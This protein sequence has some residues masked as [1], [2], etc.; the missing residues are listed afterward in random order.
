[1]VTIF[2]PQET[3]FISDGLGVIDKIYMDG[4]IVHELNGAYYLEMTVAIDEEKLFELIDYDNI[5]KAN[6]QLFRIV[7]IEKDTDFVYAKALHIFYDLSNNFLED[8]APT[9]KS[10]GDALNWILYRTV[11][12]N[13]FI[14]SSDIAN[15]KSARYVRYSPTDAIMGRL[16]NSILNTWGGEINR[17]NYSIE[18][19]SRLGQ[20]TDVEISYGKNITGI[21]ETIIKTNVVTKIMPQGFDG[22]ILPEKYVES[23]YILSYPMPV[24]R[25][26]EFKDIKVND[27]PDIG[28]VVTEAQAYDMLR[29]AAQSKFT[30]DK[31]DLPLVNYK[32]NFVDLSQTEEYKEYQVLETLNMGDTATVK[33]ERLGITVTARVIRTVWDIMRE[34]YRAIEIGNFNQ[35]LQSYIRQVNE[36]TKESI[37]IDSIESASQLIRDGLGGYTKKTREEFLIMDTTDE[38]TAQELWRW[39]RNGLGWSGTGYNGTYGIALTKDGKINASMIKTGKLLAEYIEAVSLSAISAN[40]GVITTGKLL[41][42]DGSVS[43]DIDNKEVKVGSGDNSVNTALKFNGMEVRDDQEVIA[44]FGE[45]GAV[46]PK[47]ESNVLNFSNKTGVYYVGG[48]YPYKSISECLNDLFT[49]NDKIH[50]GPAGAPNS[51]DIYIEVFG[52]INETVRITG[53]SGRG[54]LIIRINDGVTFNGNFE[55][56]GN[57]L[58]IYIIGGTNS[59]IKNPGNV[60]GYMYRISACKYVQIN[61]LNLDN[62]GGYYLADVTHGST[63]HFEECDVIN[64]NYMAQANNASSVTVVECKGNVISGVLRLTE[65]A[66]GYISGSAPAGGSLEFS[67]NKFFFT[68]G[69]VARVDSA[70]SPPPVTSKEFI[71]VFNGATFDSLHHGT[72]NVSA[73]YGA[74]AAQNRWDSQTGWFDGRIRFGSEIYNFFN[75]GSNISI[76]MRLRRKNTS[77]GSSAAVM[78]APYNHSASFPSGATRGGWTGWATIPSSLFTSGGATLTYYNGVQGSAGYAIWDAIEVEVTVTKTV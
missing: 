43:V 26:I 58:P 30:R 44:A 55:L 57:T 25:K 12:P 48:A 63:V 33:H 39:N 10:C 21:Q 36:E 66:K 69:T 73:Y 62:N 56:Y 29:A 45:N 14:G 65:G 53:L 16:E 18:I 42:A 9:D 5:I 50:I 71:Q 54:R 51:A 72:S 6:G 47:V 4:I 76:R 23:P 8:V 34:R 38:N 78:P 28:P 15:L 19:L 31:I 17:N 46:I 68:D 22:L 7:D 13:S 52:D 2:G 64:C 49:R 75:G 1:M 61:D 20:D 35:N 40:L 37:F 60:S 77:H 3:S 32:I 27:D 24:I 74:S 70:Y 11:Y 67:T 41:S 59:V